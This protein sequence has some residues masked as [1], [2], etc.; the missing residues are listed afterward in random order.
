MKNCSRPTLLGRLPVFSRQRSAATAGRKT[1]TVFL[2]CSKN[3]TG[4]L[5]F[6][7]GGRKR[8]GFRR[9]AEGGTAWRFFFILFTDDEQV[10]FC[11]QSNFDTGFFG[12]CGQNRRDARVSRSL[13]FLDVPLL[14]RPLRRW[15]NAKSKGAAVPRFFAARAGAGP[16]LGAAA[17]VHFFFLGAGIVL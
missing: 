13:L 16:A 3:G 2:I 11:L 7:V 4:P 17:A 12:R 9:S 15:A 1:D 5:P 10:L 14:P 6:G 8:A